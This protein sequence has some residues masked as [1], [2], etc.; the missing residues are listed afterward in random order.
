M[1]VYGGACVRSFVRSFVRLFVCSFVAVAAAVASVNGLLIVLC[2][3][4]R[5]WPL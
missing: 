3:I 4:R 2:L 1:D 5:A